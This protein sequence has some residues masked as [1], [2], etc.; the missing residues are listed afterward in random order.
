MLRGTIAV[1][2][3]VIDPGSLWTLPE[4]ANVI[5]RGQKV[6]DEVVARHAQRLGDIHG[7][8]LRKMD[9][10]GVEYMLLSLTSPGPQGQP[11]PAVAEKMARD[12][13]D[14]LVRDAAKNPRRFGALAALSMHDAAQ[15]ATELRRAVGMGMFGAILND[16]QSTGA[17]GKGRKYYD[18]REYDVFWQTVQ[19]LDVPVY[20]HPRWPPL[21]ELK[22]EAQAPYAARPHLLG[23]GVQFHLDL[24]FHVYAVVSSGL[25]DRY[26]NVQIVI[27]HLGE[28][29]AFNLWRA[30]W[31]YDKPN[32]KTTRPS[33]EDYGY[34]FARNVHVTTSGF[35][36][37]PNLKFVVEQ[38]GFQRVMYS[39]DTPYETIEDGQNWWKTVELPQAQKEAIGRSNAIRLFKLPLPLDD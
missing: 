25:F 14:W 32:Q 30:N 31:W 13:N 27:G 35:F 20:L 37:T 6:S 15:A 9:A 39:I 21:S 24:S 3:A 5:H 8:R 11:E 36:S 33:K 28:G 38:L 23:A 26:P 19:E 12:A 34:Y 18:E 17:D 10:E 7:E 16:F 2:E 1:E 22:P 4:A 29:T